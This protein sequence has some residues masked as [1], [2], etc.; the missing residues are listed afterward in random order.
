MEPNEYFPGSYRDDVRAFAKT[1]VPAHGPFWMLCGRTLGR[2]FDPGQPEKYVDPEGFVCMLWLLNLAHQGIYTYFPQVYWQWMSFS[3]SFPDLRGCPFYHGNLLT[4]GSLLRF[5]RDPG[6]IPHAKP[7]EL[8]EKRVRAFFNFFFNDYLSGL[9][10]QYPP[11]V[12]RFSP[13]ELL[14]HLRNDPSCTEVSC[15]G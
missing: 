11:G 1:N 10:G 6:Y 3:E 7:L 12:R 14:A 4:P 8:D 15:Y 5:A 13:T 9:N 2:L